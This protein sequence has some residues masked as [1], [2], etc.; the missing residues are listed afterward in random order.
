MRDFD[1]L[2]ADLPDPYPY[3]ARAR[4][5]EPVFHAPAIGAWCVTRYEDIVAVATDTDTFSSRESLPRP[6]GTPP[7]LDSFLRWAFDETPPATFLDPPR[8]TRV[9]RVLGK[10]FTPRA[11]ASFEPRIR[12]IVRSRIDAVRAREEFDLVTDLARPIPLDV[13]LDVIGVPADR[14]A[15]FEKWHEQLVTV[16]LGW[17]VADEAVL[18]ECAAGLRDARAWLTAL[19]AEREAEPREDLVSFLVH[20]DVRGHRLTPDEVAMQLML[21]VSAGH[22][23]TANTLVNTLHALM[24]DPGAWDDYVSG[25]VPV[26]RIVEEGLRFDSSV[27]AQFR[28]ATRDTEIAGVPV[29]AGAQVMIALGSGNHDGSR[30]PDP[31]RFRPDRE[32]PAPHMA[33]GHGVHHCVGAPLARLELRVALEETAAAFPRLRPAPGEGT[34]E[35]RLPVVNFRG[36]TR[37]RVRP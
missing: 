37:L 6:Q 33:F 19:V 5:A 30:Y 20:G 10:G 24:R 32:N 4:E 8:H 21:L 35:A 29:P 25:R 2:G 36:L 27:I 1:P 3:F 22:E 13:I 12:D 16:T 23:T 18:Q 7:E 31:E 14:H 34:A 11:L 28:T 15:E 9:R 26:E 17:R